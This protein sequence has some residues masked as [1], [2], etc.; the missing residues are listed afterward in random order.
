MQKSV[1]F[2]HTN[3]EVYEKEINLIYSDTKNNKIR[4]NKFNLGGERSRHWKLQDIDERNQ[5]K[6][7][8]WKGIPCLWVRRINII[9]M[10]MLLKAIC[11]FNA[12]PIKI[13]MA[14]FT[15][16]EKNTPNM[17]IELKKTP[18]SQRNPEKEEQS[19]RHHNSWFQAFL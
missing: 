12:I 10:P 4:R 2:L 7:N 1:A 8:K 15:E 19:R 6:Q 16:V 5:R 3:N 13:P 17:Y 14:F 9:K 11:G 18:S